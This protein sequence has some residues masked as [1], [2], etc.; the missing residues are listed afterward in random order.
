MSLDFK[1]ITLVEFVFV[2]VLV[3]KVGQGFHVYWNEKK[4]AFRDPN[5]I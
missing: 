3:E 4:N 2:T 1:L 5:G